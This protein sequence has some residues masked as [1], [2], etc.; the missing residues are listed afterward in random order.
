MVLYASHLG[1][2]ERGLLSAGAMWE[3]RPLAWSDCQISLQLRHVVSQKVALNFFITV[4]FIVALRQAV[5]LRVCVA[6]AGAFRNLTIAGGAA[7]CEHMAKK[8]VLSVRFDA[9]LFTLCALF[10]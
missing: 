4:L 9:L 2:V 10:D 5:D 6:A 3:N 1:S 7:A 8:D